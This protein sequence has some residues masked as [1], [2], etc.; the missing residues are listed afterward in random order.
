MAQSTT[1]VPYI[2]GLYRCAVSIARNPTDSEDLV[3]ETYVRVHF[4]PLC[5]PAAYTGLPARNYCRR[6]DRK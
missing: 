5:Q 3:Q 1:V 2:H 6:Q 4:A